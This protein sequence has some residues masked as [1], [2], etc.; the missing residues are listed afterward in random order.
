MIID[1]NWEIH[2]IVTKQT[3]SDLMKM[4]SALGTKTDKRTFTTFVQEIVGKI[5]IFIR[6][7]N[8]L[9]LQQTNFVV[10]EWKTVGVD[11]V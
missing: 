1:Q 8:A 2:L 6:N 3:G 7:I 4:L 11:V 5:K 10:G 9:I